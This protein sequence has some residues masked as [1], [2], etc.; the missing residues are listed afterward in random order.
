MLDISAP[1]FDISTGHTQGDKSQSCIKFS[2]DGWVWS[3]PTQE[4]L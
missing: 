2:Q 4:K 1:N 3:M